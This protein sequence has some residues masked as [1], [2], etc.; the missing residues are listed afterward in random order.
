M[1]RNKV[2]AERRARKNRSRA[3]RKLAE[4]RFLDWVPPLNSS[5]PLSDVIFEFAQPMIGELR[6][7]A[8]ELTRTLKLAAIAWNTAIMFQDGDLVDLAE[9]A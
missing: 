8:V 6:L 4:R 5:S 9:L 2:V 3:Q 7:D 1:S